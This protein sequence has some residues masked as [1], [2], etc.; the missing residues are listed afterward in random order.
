MNKYRQLA[1]NTIIFAIG[2]FGS[3]IFSLLLN[4]LYTRHISPAGFYSKTLIETAALFLLPVFTFSLTEAVVRY[5]LDRKYRKKQIFTTA[6]VL[7]FAGLMLMILAMPFIELIP[8]LSPIR[9][10]TVML[11]VYVCI[12]SVRSLCSQFVRARGMVR[13]FAFDGIFT[14]MTLFIFNILFISHMKMGVLGFMLSVILSDAC[15]SV[16]LFISA[17]LNH[18]LDIHSF[19]KKLAVSMMKFSLPLIPTTVMWTFTGFSDQIFIGN[20]CSEESAGIYSASTKLPNLLSMVSTIFFQAWNI[21]AITENDSAGRNEFY[22]K[23]YSAYESVLFIGSAGLILLIKPISAILINYDTYPEYSTAYLYA[24]VLITAAVFTCLDQF[25][26][27]IYTAT[28]HTI[29]SLVTVTIA[30]TANIILNTHLIPIWSIQ[31]A[32]IATFM[33]YFICFWIRMA[34]ARRYVPFR[35]SAL[36]NIIN[37]C[38][39]LAMCW[40]TVR[41]GS[42]VPV[43]VSAVAVLLMNA[44]ALLVT[45]KMLIKR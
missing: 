7:I 43:I 32:S 42:F 40:L 35:F 29:N 4:N 15:S 39:I 26:S 33:S 37:T 34:D 30:C 14:T 41:Q 2:S 18:Y 36:K 28:K 45:V 9:E 21:S 3:K 20:L 8:F 5:G 22:E 13:L 11:T 24:P 38:I 25:L 31:G 23:V 19:N 6:G 1:F 44:K 27:G 16:F 17:G 12:S 10:Y